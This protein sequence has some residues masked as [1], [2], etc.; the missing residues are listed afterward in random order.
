MK[1]NTQW[2]VLAAV[3]VVIALFA[4]LAGRGS[5]APA[6]APA[7]EAPAADSSV[8]AETP[9]EEVPEEPARIANDLF[10]LDL[11]EDLKEICEAEISDNGVNIYDKEAK[12]NF[13][14]FAFGLSAYENPSDY[15]SPMVTKI[16]EMTK[17]DGTIYDVVLSQPSDVQYDFQ[18]PAAQERYM[19]LY[20]SWEDVA[21]NYFKPV[22]GEYV[23]GAGTKGEDLYGDILQ[24]Y[25]KVLTED[26]AE[27]VEEPEAAEE[28]EPAE[29]AETAEA[30][31]PAE[32]AEPEET[33]EAAQT[34]DVPMSPIFEVIAMDKKSAADIAGYA[35][36]DVNQD[37]VEELLV[38]EI[39]EDE[40]KGVIYDV[41]T[42]VDRAPAHVVSGWYRNRFYTME[43]GLLVNEFSNGAAE[44]G[45][46]VYDIA[47]NAAELV[48][49]CAFKYDGYESEEEPWFVS[50]NYDAEA[51]E[52]TDWEK[53][54]EEEWNLRMGNF[55][56]YVR[57]DYTPF[58]SLI[59][60][61]EPAAE[62]PAAEET[63]EPAEAEAPAEEAPAEEAPAEEAPA[64]E[65]APAEEPA[66]EP[67]IGMPN[68][69]KEITAEEAAAACG[70]L[71]AVPEGAENA[72]WS[73]MEGENPLVQLAYE[74][75]GKSFTARAQENVAA[76][77][78]ISGMFYEWKSAEDATVTVSGKEFP[79]KICIA[80]GEK[81]TAELI[82]WYDEETKTSYSLSTVAEDVEGFDIKAVAEGM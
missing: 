45:I 22:D 32:A 69:W 46:A 18:D 56:N 15:A 34:A 25:V 19:K 38:G 35:Y 4:V 65:A 50:Y 76:G 29:A 37:G 54:S 79:A 8:A 40:W 13:G 77:E 9:A 27:P 75:N 80:P 44:N 62:E 78:D 16:G 57:F 10:E 82:T 5:K 52:W 58:S 26:A 17:A 67:L 49:Q 7:A 81:E 23:N 61:E 41:F 33:P 11:P 43:G 28:A 20:D 73:I 63:A 36:Y 59:P 1:K 12:E 6:Q 2:I 71:F 66:A 42:M 24:A 31:E 30:T 48:P 60:K 21:A 72:V 70:N 14:G 55:E 3:L 47:P 64:E 74:L 51:E 39:A 53:L 68:P